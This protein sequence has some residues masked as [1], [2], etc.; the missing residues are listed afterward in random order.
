[1]DIAKFIHNLQQKPE[2][3]KKVILWVATVVIMAFIFSGWLV[4]F[5]SEMQ[6]VSLA[7]KPKQEKQGALANLWND[8]KNDTASLKNVFNIKNEK[9]SSKTP[10]SETPAAT[11]SK[12]QNKTSQPITPNK[13][14]LSN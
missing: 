14:P 3:T 8:I 6:D 5:S 7:G 11:P 2:P 10:A 12:E 4:S 1:M 9:E 13:L